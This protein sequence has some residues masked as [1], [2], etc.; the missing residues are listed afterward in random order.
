MKERIIAVVTLL[1]VFSSL[2]A[3]FFVNDYGW[4]PDTGRSWVEKCC[5]IIFCMLI[6]GFIA[7][8]EWDFM[9]LDARDYANLNILPIRTS[10]IF[11]AKFAS[12][13]LFVGLFALSIHS[14]STL[15]FVTYLPHWQSS[16]AFFMIAF[17][18]A[19]IISMFLACFFAFFFFILLIS[20]LMAVLGYRLFKRVSTYIR[21]FFL[22]VHILFF[23]VYIRITLYGFDK[24][25]PLL[26]LK[27]NHYDLHNLPLFF[28]PLW[29]TDLYETLIGNPHLPFHG[30]LYYALIGLVSMVVIFYL[31]TN[32]GYR[33][34][35]IKMDSTRRK[36]TH[37]KRMRKFFP[38]IF[39][40]AF[41][42]NPVQRAVF[43]F[44][45]NSVYASTFHKMRLASFVAFGIG[46][47][48]FQ[49]AMKKLIPG[50]L[51]GVNRTM[52][53]LS[54]I[55]MVFYL[56]G[57]RGVINMPIS[58]DANWIFKLTEHKKIHHY[59]TGLKKGIFFI[60]LLPLFIIFFIFYSFLWGWIIAIYHCLYVLALSVLVMEVFFISYNKI[61]FAC[62]YLPGKEKMQFLWVVYLFLYLAFINLMSWIELEILKTP[63]Y[64]IIFYAI[65][66]LIILGIRFFQLFFFYKNKGIKY[67]EVL[68]PVMV[69]LDY[70]MPLYKKIN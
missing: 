57:L 2:L 11:T 66:C 40:M 38:H 47:I 14:L 8:L 45:R 3:Y 10:T 15:I 19:H 18:L 21:S 46:M 30:T 37:L 50:D 27:E 53:S 44:Y 41:L 26:K 70:E 43:H 59:F 42:R 65:S 63:S 51:T 33:R 54:F 67:E 58:L 22:V 24:F 64:I 34:Y 60:N 16:N 6:M 32:L 4:M 49:I 68:D 69:G 1:F 7:V 39:H 17:A 9:L 13:C 52:L 62:S 36:R 31:T 55:L 56:I 35:L 61:P 12:L 25:E 28:P 20:M 5:M 23:F 48:P 29:F